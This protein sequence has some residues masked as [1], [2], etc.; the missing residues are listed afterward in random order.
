MENVCGMMSDLL[1]SDHGVP[2]HSKYS[3]GSRAW[4]VRFLT[5]F[6]LLCSSKTACQFVFG[7]R[8]YSCLKP[9]SVTLYG[10]LTHRV[11]K[12]SLPHWP[13]RGPFSPFSIWFISSSPVYLPLFGQAWTSHSLG[14]TK[15]A[16]SITGRQS[17][18]VQAREQITLKM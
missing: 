17:I 2:M 9:M 4:Y 16:P 18:L 15:I 5:N 14:H 11:F 3:L 7:L 1:T 10:V 6:A 12:S 8:K 13:F